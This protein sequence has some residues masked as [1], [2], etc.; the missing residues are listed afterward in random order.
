[1][2]AGDVLYMVLLGVI[3]VLAMDIF[4][5]W[6]DLSEW[7]NE[8]IEKVRAKFSPPPPGY[9]CSACRNAFHS[10]CISKAREPVRHTKKQCQCR[11]C[12]PK[13]AIKA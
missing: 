6:D 4:H 12:W 13:G 5:L 2:T 9:V 8:G 10:Y 7:V 3:L 11:H 1:M